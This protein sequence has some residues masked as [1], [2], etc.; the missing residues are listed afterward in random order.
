MFKQ[1]VIDKI[2]SAISIKKCW[3]DATNA[4]DQFFLDGCE[5]DGTLYT[6]TDDCVQV[7]YSSEYGAE[8]HY[9][10]SFDEFLAENIDA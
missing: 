10:M 1:E 7:Y 6:V 5:C 3:L 8:K 4:P 9:T 2:K